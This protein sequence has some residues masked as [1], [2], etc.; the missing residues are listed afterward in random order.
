M[1]TY[2]KPQITVLFVPI[3]QV[4]ETSQWSFTIFSVLQSNIINMNNEKNSITNEY[5]HIKQL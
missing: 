2:S 1:F 4:N 3:L 5:K